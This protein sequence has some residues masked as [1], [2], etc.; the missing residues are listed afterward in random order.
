MG[1][2]QVYRED[3]DVGM[4]YINSMQEEADYVLYF[5][6]EMNLINILQKE[7]EVEKNNE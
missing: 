3:I 2:I 6:N 7:S 1:K 5:D 4:I